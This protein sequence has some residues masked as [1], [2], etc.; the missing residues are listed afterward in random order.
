MTVATCKGTT[1]DGNPCGA[2]VRAG[3]GFCPWH[4]PEFAGKRSE[5][6]R[7]GGKNS[8]IKARTRKALPDGALSITETH[9]LMGKVLVDLIAGDIEPAIATAASNVARTIDTL[10]RGSELE[11][12]IS[13]MREDMARFIERQGAAS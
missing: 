7:Q 9:A 10:A 12:Q 11:E 4:D 13:Q 2:Q 1:K 3:S 8:S 5:W 6:S